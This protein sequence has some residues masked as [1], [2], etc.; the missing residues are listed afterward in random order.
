MFKLY[1]TPVRKGLARAVPGQTFEALLRELCLFGTES[2]ETV[3]LAWTSRPGL[4]QEW[5]GAPEHEQ[6]IAR[7]IS[8]TNKEYDLRSQIL[9]KHLDRD[10]T[11]TILDSHVGKFA[12]EVAMSRWRLIRKL[13]LNGTGATSGLAYDGQYFFDTDHSL[14]SSGAQKNLLTASEIPVLNVG[15]STAPTPEEMVDVIMGVI[16]WMMS[17]LDEKGEPFMVDAR[18]FVVLPAPTMWGAAQTA[19]RANNLAGG[20]TNVVRGLLGDQFSVTA[21]NDPGLFSGLTNDH[22]YV[23]MTGDPFVKPFVF[24]EEKAPTYDLLDADS[25]YAKTTKSICPIAEGRWGANFGEALTMVKVTL[26]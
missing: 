11:G 1:S 2:G 17:F 3:K 26:S 25:E 19:L 6:P 7:E 4:M 21:A 23:A 16:G 5:S 8:V 24:N 20:E 12:S 15:T 14:G 13:I 22:L 18:R 10:E 9:L